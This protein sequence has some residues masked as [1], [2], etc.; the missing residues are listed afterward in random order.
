MQ[1]LQKQQNLKKIRFKIQVTK[2]DKKI[3]V[4]SI[5]NDLHACRLDSFFE[6][7]CPKLKALKII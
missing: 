1:S 6:L 4:I 5:L 3:L 7:N 2:T